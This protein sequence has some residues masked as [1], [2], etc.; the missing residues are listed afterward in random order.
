MAVRVCFAP[1]TE[2]PVALFAVPFNII[3]Y[4]E[5]E[6]CMQQVK[7]R[8]VQALTGAVI[9]SVL[10]AIPVALGFGPYVWV[11]FMP[12]ILFFALGAKF[13]LI[14]GIILCYA[15]GI[16][17]TYGFITVQ[18]FI[19]GL[20][21]APV[22]VELIPNIL[23]VFLVLTVHENLLRKT[24]FGIVPAVF[25]GLATAFYAVFSLAPINGLHLMGFFCYGLVM[26]V[27]LMVGGVAVSS[28]IFG[29]AAAMA[30]FA[31]G[32]AKPE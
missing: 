27:A 14:P 26:T 2:C 31:S 5:R 8:M 11:L 28:L 20:T 25:M 24:P 23:L 6:I 12:L 22:F 13:R 7:I 3:Y 17:W 32:A 4:Q 1:P 10:M 30:T 9:L 29:K 15:C 19:K 18:G 21:S 16:L